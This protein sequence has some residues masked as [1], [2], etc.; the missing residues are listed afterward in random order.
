VPRSISLTLVLAAAGK[1]FPCARG[2]ARRRMSR[3]NGR[4][5]CFC[6]RQPPESRLSADGFIRH[7]V[8]LG[9]GTTLWIEFSSLVCRRRG[10]LGS[11]NTV[12][13]SVRSHLTFWVTTAASASWSAWAVVWVGG[14]LLICE[15][16][17]PA[18]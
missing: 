10:A 8:G 14:S 15:A 18:A 12:R 5:R 9:C 11:K 6:K 1:A 17:V 16:W 13:I 4:N 2:P 3:P 7:G